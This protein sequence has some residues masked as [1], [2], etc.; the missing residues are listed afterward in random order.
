[1]FI[2]KSSVEARTLVEK[3]SIEARTLVE[4]SSVEAR[5][6]VEKSS[7]EAR[8]LVEKSSIEARALVEKSSIEARALVEKSSIEARTLVEKSS[9]EARTLVEKSSIETR[10]LVAKPHIKIEKGINDEHDIFFKKPNL[11][12]SSTPMIQMAS[13]GNTLQPLSKRE[14]IKVLFSLITD[15]INGNNK[16]QKQHLRAMF[17]KAILTKNIALFKELMIELDLYELSNFDHYTKLLDL[18]K[19]DPLAI[20]N[21]SILGY[22]QVE[23]AKEEAKPLIS[24]LL[25]VFQSIPESSKDRSGIC[26]SMRTKKELLPKLLGQTEPQVKMPVLSQLT[27]LSFDSLLPGFRPF[28]GD[29]SYIPAKITHQQYLNIITKNVDQSIF[30]VITIG[31]LKSN[32]LAS[33]E[34]LQKL[35][36]DYLFIDYEECLKSIEKHFQELTLP[37]GFPVGYE[38]YVRSICQSVKELDH[39]NND[40]RRFFETR[41]AQYINGLTHSEETLTLIGKPLEGLFDD[42]KLRLQTLN[43]ANKILNFFLGPEG[44]VSSPLEMERKICIF[45]NGY[46]DKE[47]YNTEQ[48]EH[49]MKSCPAYNTRDRIPKDKKTGILERKFE[50]SADKV[51]EDVWNSAG[52]VMR[53]I[54]PTFFDAQRDP[55]RNMLVDSSEVSPKKETSSTQWFWSNKRFRSAY[56]GSISGH[57]CNIVFMLNRYMQENQKDPNLSQDINLF[58]IQLVAVYAKRGYHGMLEVMDILHDQK[59]QEIF[60]KNNVTLDL[61]KY[62]SIDPDVGAFLEY[63]MNDTSIYA[64]VLASKHHVKLELARF[65]LQMEPSREESVNH[66]RSTTA[67]E[68]SSSVSNIK[69]G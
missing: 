3:S 18:H 40:T 62:F 14:P 44:L 43:A 57:T 42:S 2:E 24:L 30:I 34:F 61:M 26:L 25:N 36:A 7:V 16:D 52:G 12:S 59:V 19:R 8:A 67:T 46:K 49:F 53:S 29:Q 38:Q 37:D 48:L 27:D 17:L 60:K 10:E 65:F 4:K 63:A 32:K 5:T 68:A 47:K 15:K 1:M 21:S 69:V 41:L 39:K 11:S 66:Q 50:T 35:A 33:K 20:L 55:M 31:Y 54:S 58:L 6:L 56:V 28:I 51:G 45:A 22:V 9:I 64:Q 13:A 23:L